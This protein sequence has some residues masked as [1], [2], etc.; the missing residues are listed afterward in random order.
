MDHYR[1]AKMAAFSLIKKTAYATLPRKKLAELEYIKEF[2]RKPDFK[3]PTRFTEKMWLLK[4]IN[5]RRQKGLLQQC[6]DKY[7]VRDYVK[8]KL[9]YESKG[10]LNELYGVYNSADE[11][12]FDALPD[13]FALKVTQSS[14]CNYLC[15]DKSKIDEEAVRETFRVWLD[16]ARRWMPGAGAESYLLDG[17]ARIIAEKLLVTNGGVPHD[18][19]VFCFHGQP[20]LFWCS[21]NVGDT[22]RWEGAHGSMPVGNT[23]DLAWKPLN[24]DLMTYPHK[25]EL[26]FEKPECLEKILRISRILSEDFLFARIDFLMVD[27][28]PIFGEITFVHNGGYGRFVPDRY[29]KLFGEMLDIDKYL[30][31]AK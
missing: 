3:N 16:T 7:R 26:Y 5:G 12:D 6:Y 17:K 22:T 30:C 20:K 10:F 13:S 19:R 28:T 29:D 31:Y 9:G 1:Y 11:I 25:E 23:Y 14:G 18:L 27:K 15:P 24:L 4:L 8:E 2:M 21:K